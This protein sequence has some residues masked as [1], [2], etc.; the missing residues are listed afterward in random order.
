MDI[1]TCQKQ[2]TQGLQHRQLADKISLFDGSLCSSTE[3]GTVDWRTVDRSVRTEMGT[4]DG[5][6]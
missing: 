2:S 6:I 4:V 3:S 1:T 5:S